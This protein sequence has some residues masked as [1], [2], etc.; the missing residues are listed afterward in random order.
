MNSKRISNAFQDACFVPSKLLLNET[1]G[2]KV[3]I[4]VAIV[5][6]LFRTMLYSA[7][8]CSLGVVFPSHLS[9]QKRIS[10]P[11][12]IEKDP[13]GKKNFFVAIRPAQKCE[14]PG[15]QRT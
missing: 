12:L 6:V 9:S 8:Y 7:G 1:F 14:S 4:T 5:S 2:G 15:F 11:S 10:Y 3:P 13:C